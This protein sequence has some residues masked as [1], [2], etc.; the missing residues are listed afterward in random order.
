MA[1]GHLHVD[2]AKRHCALSLG[3][4]SSR[5]RRIHEHLELAGCLAEDGGCHHVDGV[6]A[7]EGTFPTELTETSPAPARARAAEG[8]AGACNWLGIAVFI[9]V[10]LVIVDH[11]S[12]L[13]ISTAPSAASS[14]STLS[15][16][17]RC[18]AL[19]CSWRW[20]RFNS[21]GV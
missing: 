12:E 21:G 16:R 14:P 19:A 10:E 20:S 17:L 8:V 1:T 9:I 18:S 11:A 2:D 15:G 4:D 13:I 5:H 3:V 6:T 7:S